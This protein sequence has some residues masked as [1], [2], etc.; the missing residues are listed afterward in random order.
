MYG[1]NSGLPI[2]TV[3]QGRDRGFQIYVSYILVETP[4]YVT[5][6]WTVVQQGPCN[7]VTS[8]TYMPISPNNS[9]TGLFI[10]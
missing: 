5:S 9:A 1:S 10:G 2:G 4:T 7:N 6:G 8:E 3:P